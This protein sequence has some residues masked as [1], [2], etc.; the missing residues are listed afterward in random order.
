M[1][2]TSAGSAREGIRNP[3]ISKSVSPSY[4]NFNSFW[5]DYKKD[6]DIWNMSDADYRNLKKRAKAFYEKYNNR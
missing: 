5:N 1:A 4:K 2:C 3:S 6:F